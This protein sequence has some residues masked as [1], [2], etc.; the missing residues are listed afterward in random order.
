MARISVPGFSA[1]SNRLAFQAADV[2]DTFNMVPEMISPGT[3]QKGPVV[4]LRDAPGVQLYGTVADTPGRFS[5]SQDGRTF[6]ITGN[7]FWELFTDGT[8]TIWGTVSASA[9]YSIVSN[10]SAG[11]QLMIVTGGIVYVFNL[12]T[13]TLT[14][15]NG[16]GLWTTPGAGAQQC[17]FLDG[18]GIVTQRE[19][20]RWFISA[21]EDFTTWDPLDVF[22]RSRASD[23]LVALR[24]R[25]TDLFLFGSA[26]S[27]VW[28][29]SGDALTPFQA[30]PALLNYGTANPMSVVRFREQIA[31]LES[32][33][34]GGGI[35]SVTQGYDKQ[36]ISDDAVEQD[37]QSVGALNFSFL[38]VLQM[39]GHEFLA[40]LLPELT[41]T[42][43]YDAATHIWTKW[44]LWNTTTVAWETHLMQSA[45]YAFSGSG[46]AVQLVTDRTSGNIYQLS[47]DAHSNG[48]AS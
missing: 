20:R 17:E 39:Q 41:W 33:P 40:L 24:R 45:T 11:N 10:G 23:N 16:T 37:I 19:S 31:F 18:Y 2:E 26:T 5:F 9:Q 47:F 15:V 43:V 14:T 29:D 28:F 35:V 3:A 4:Y 44:A 6:G 7:S 30:A 22:E 13:N 1:G 34:T 8:T 12:L 46:N 25:G 32:G 48:I 36:R 21:L 27:E 38:M 42:W